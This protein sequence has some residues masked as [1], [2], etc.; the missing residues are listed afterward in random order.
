MYMPS[1]HGR[2]YSFRA[3]SA[4]LC[5]PNEAVY[6]SKL[7]WIIFFSMPEAPGGYAGAD[8]VFE[9]DLKAV[10]ERVAY[11]AGVTINARYPR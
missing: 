10:E 9:G 11:M 8:L 4:L 3:L 2:I 6:R 1:T 7:Y 5:I